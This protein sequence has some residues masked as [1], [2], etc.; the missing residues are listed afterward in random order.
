MDRKTARPYVTPDEVHSTT[1]E[2]ALPKNQTWIQLRFCIQT[3]IYRKSKK[4][5]DVLKQPHE[6]ASSKTRVWKSLQDKHLSFLKKNRQGKEKAGRGI[7][8]LI[9]TKETD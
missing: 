3:P 9:E 5:R 8:R 6:D 7:L 2:I 1:F 4:E